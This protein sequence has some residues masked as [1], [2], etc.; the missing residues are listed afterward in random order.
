M[1]PREHVAW[2]IIFCAIL[3]AIFPNFSLLGLVIIF[4][5]SV[6]IDIDHYIIAVMETKR[7]WLGDA[8]EF[9]RLHNIEE[10]KAHKKGI[11]KKGHFHV[12]HTV[13]AHFMIFGLSFL[14]APFAYVFLGMVFHSLCDLFELTKEDRLY[15]REFWFTRGIIKRLKK[16]H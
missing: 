5:S 3:F 2:G 11:R 12:L 1:F 10:E 13:E 14:W 8:L 15:R 16:T 6:L 7:V 4:L 9:Y